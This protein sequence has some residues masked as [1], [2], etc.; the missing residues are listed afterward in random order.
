MIFHLILT[1]IKQVQELFK[2]DE[3]LSSSWKH[4]LNI[5]YF[6]HIYIRQTF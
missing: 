3:I 5:F 6:P 4:S 2:G 1:F